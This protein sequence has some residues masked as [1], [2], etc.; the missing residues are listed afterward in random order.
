[1]VA[2]PAK[3]EPAE[4]VRAKPLE[5]EAR[6]EPTTSAE[7]SQPRRAKEHAAVAAAKAAPAVD[8]ETRVPEATSATAAAPADPP[9]AKAAPAPELAPATTPSPETLGFANPFRHRER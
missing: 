5:P 3:A 1:M 6:A 2:E 9:P 4:D 8:P 7:G